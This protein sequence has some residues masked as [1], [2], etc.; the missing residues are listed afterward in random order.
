MD[1]EF[2]ICDVCSAT[3]GRL[4]AYSYGKDN[5]MQVKGRLGVVMCD[6]CVDFQLKKGFKRVF[7]S[8]LT[9]T[10]A[11]VILGIWGWAGDVETLKVIGIII[12]V[13]FILLMVISLID[14][15]KD[16]RGTKKD[17]GENAAIIF[18]CWRLLKQNFNKWWSSDALEKELQNNPQLAMDLLK[19]S[20]EMKKTAEI[21]LY[22]DMFP[23]Q[24]MTQTK[25]RSV[26]SDQPIEVEDDSP[27]GTIKR[28]IF[29]LLTQPRVM[30]S[31]MGFKQTDLE[32]ALEQQGFKSDFSKNF[33]GL[34]DTAIRELIQ[35]GK[36][37]QRGGWI[38][39]AKK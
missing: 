16:L 35:E 32:M 28:Q 10:V 15:K 23:P 18:S 38:R 33:Y 25:D 5:P 12:F 27:Q 11:A 22:R 29:S 30:A 36:L 9:G 2:S 1:P 19:N 3:S 4:Y 7:F 31:G 21:I 39:A 20:T 37:Q 34:V 26:S 14:R 17:R 6:K 24:K 13:V 8:G